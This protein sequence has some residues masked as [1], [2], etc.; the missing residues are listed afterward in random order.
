MKYPLSRIHY[1]P[2]H[3]HKQYLKTTSRSPLKNFPRPKVSQLDHHNYL[4]FPH[5]YSLQNP[6]SHWLRT[7]TIILISRF[8]E[9]SREITIWRFGLIPPSTCH[10]TTLERGHINYQSTTK[11]P[12]IHIFTFSF[13]HFWSIQ[14]NGHLSSLYHHHFPNQINTSPIWYQYNNLHKHE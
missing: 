4:N 5:E 2:L 1:N 10:K 7:T 9:I 11:S 14:H 3:L 6:T 13:V 8:T 12:T